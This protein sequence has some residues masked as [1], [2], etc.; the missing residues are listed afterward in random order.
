MRRLIALRPTSPFRGPAMDHRWIADRMST[1][2]SSGIRKVFDLA[3][4]LTD[5]IDLSIGQPDFDVPEAIRQAA[6]DAIQSGQNGYALT[7]GMPVLRERLQQQVDE[8]FD[9]PDRKL[10]VTSGTSGGLMLALMSLVNPGD[11][12][13]I[14]DPFFVMYPALVGVVGGDSPYTWIR[15]PI[16]GS[17]SIGFERPLPTVPKRS[18]STARPI[19]RVPSRQRPTLQPWRSWAAERNVALISDEIYRDFCYDEPFRSPA[20]HNPETIVIDGFSKSYAMTGWRLGFAHGPA[21]VIDQMIKLQQYSFVCAPHPFQLAA[22]AA[23]D[24]DMQSHFDA[25]RGKR[26]RL[27]AG[28]EADFHFTAPGGAF[29]FVF[30]SSLGHGNRVRHGMYFRGVVGDSRQRPSAAPT[31]TSGCLMPPRTKPSIAASRCSRGWPAVGR[32]R[33]PDRSSAWPPALGRNGCSQKKSPGGHDVAPGLG[34]IERGLEFP[35][36]SRSAVR[37]PHPQA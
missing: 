12:V 33:P 9:H 20:E 1:F 34:C 26:D 21:A 28:L 2:D 8:R 35:A 22:A 4:Q 31:R 37:A 13:I 23:L 10:F 29:L 27:V 24:V 5:P 14:F 15:T 6:V 3:S 17:T 30:G 32:I 25:Y 18:W 36:G 19:R 16:F 7:Q 11:E